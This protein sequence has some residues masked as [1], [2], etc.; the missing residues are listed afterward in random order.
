[1]DIWVVL[2]AE[3]ALQQMKD[4]MDQGHISGI[5]Q[6]TQGIKAYTNK[7]KS[8][9]QEKGGSVVLSMDGRLVLQLPSSAAN[10]LEKIIEG[11]SLTVDAPVAVGIGLSY[12]EAVKASNKSKYT[13]ELELFDPSMDED[14]KPTD[15]QLNRR[16]RKYNKPYN[17]RPTDKIPEIPTVE[18][19]A[20]LNQSLIQN[21]LSELGLNEVMQAQQQQM[22]SMEE[23]QQEAEAEAEEQAMQQEQM[24]NQEPQVDENGQP[25]ETQDPNQE[26]EEQPE[27]ARAPGT[28]LDALIGHTVTEEE[29]PENIEQDY[30][31][32]EQAASS[33][34]EATPEGQ[35]L[36]QQIEPEV[37]EAE[38]A[39]EEDDNDPFTDK[40]GHT[41]NMVH[42]KLPEIMSMRSQDPEGFKETMSSI[43]RL[44]NAAKK[45]NV[46]KAEHL[47]EEIAKF[48][49]MGHH[50][51]WPVGSR[52][53]RMQKVKL[54]DG[55]EV[56]RS[57]TSGR[58][59]SNEDGQAVSVRH[60]NE[61]AQDQ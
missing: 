27:M 55:R 52:K 11:Y 42:D 1:M 10:E 56:W 25:V 14:F 4:W 5:N 58:V 22:E 29:T 60:H 28:L 21:M 33:I 20:K 24:G 45:K 41:L 6:L 12:N 2:N 30:Q 26:T 16:T 15:G 31:M 19:E 38:E 18:Q 46:K 34:Q 61:E 8:Y 3:D 51:K 39:A 50:N 37:V 57:M 44:M 17:G 40:I 53:G 49:R 47:I 59:K 48:S 32:I 35:E 43:V 7:L 54:P 13:G 36:A 9:A 23:Q